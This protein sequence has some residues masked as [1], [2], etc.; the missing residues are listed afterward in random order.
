MIGKFICILFGIMSAVSF[1]QDPSYEQIEELIQK[2]QTILRFEPDPFTLARTQEAVDKVYFRFLSIIKKNGST[3]PS[4][5]SKVTETLKKEKTYQ[6][7]F[8]QEILDETSEHVRKNDLKKIEFQASLQALFLLKAYIQKFLVTQETQEDQEN[9]NKES[10]EDKKN[11][12]KQKE[13][14]QKEKKP[15]REDDEEYKDLDADQYDPHTKDLENDNNDG[16][17]LKKRVLAETNVLTEYFKSGYMSQIVRNAKENNKA[18]QK[19]ELFEEKPVITT[20]TSQNYI[21]V[22]PFKNKSPFLLYLPS[23]MKPLKPVTE[24]ISIIRRKTGQ[25]EVKIHQGATLTDITIPLEE[26]LQILPPHLLDHYKQKVGFHLD[27]WPLEIR[28]VINTMNQDSSLSALQIAKAVAKLISSQYLYSTKGRP[29]KDPI[30]ALKAGAFQCDMAAYILIG[31]LRDYFQIPSRVAFG[32]RAKFSTK[33]GL[34]KRFL[35]S[36]ED[37]HAW[38]EIYEAGIWHPV[39]PTPTKKESKDQDDD[40]DDQSEYQDVPPEDPD[41][42]SEDQEKSSKDQE[43]ESQ[44]NTDKSSKDSSK[45]EQTPLPLE[46]ESKESDQSKEDSLEDMI[47]REELIQQ[48]EMDSATLIKDNSSGP[49]LTYFKLKLLK[50]TIDPLNNNEAIVNKLYILKNALKRSSDTLFKNK[51]EKFIKDHSLPH[52]SLQNWLSSLAILKDPK[53]KHQSYLRVKHYLTDYASILNTLL[54]TSQ[55]KTLEKLRAE[56]I[57]ILLVIEDILKKIASYSMSTPERISA[58]KQFYQ[59]L[60]PM[61]KKYIKETYNIKELGINKETENLGTAIFNGQLNHLI[62]VSNLASQADFNLSG[63]PIPEFALFKAWSEDARYPTGRDILP[64]TKMSDLPRAYLG[65]PHKSWEENIN[66]STVF[67]I[68]QKEVFEVPDESGDIDETER[69]T[70]IGFDQSG[71]MFGIPAE[72]QAALM[73]AFVT[74]AFSDVSPTGKQ[75]HKIL[76][77]PFHHDVLPE[78]GIT[79]SDDAINVLHNYKK[80]QEATGGTDIQKFLIQALSLIANAQ[81]RTGEPLAKANIILMTDG[82]AN[83]DLQELKEARRVIDRSTPIQTIFVSLGGGNDQL[84]EFS[85]TSKGI[86]IKESFYRE[87]SRSDMETLINESKDPKKLWSNEEMFF[88]SELKEIPSEGLKV[89][90]NH[91]NSLMWEYDN[92]LEQDVQ[93]R[94]LKDILRDL[95]SINAL[96]VASNDVLIDDIASVRRLTGKLKEKNRYKKLDAILSR[97]YKDYKNIMSKP[98]SQMSTHELESFVHLFKCAEGLE[99]CQ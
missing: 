50:D 69:I 76:L 93:Y 90:Y 8:V 97:V 91:L 30:D 39:D 37:G 22:Y 51:I 85:S 23:K 34:A 95:G 98:V 46:D 11:P 7:Q 74:K 15:Q 94:S 12:K 18:F 27:E 49:L 77:V 3:Y 82:E 64:L 21:K 84:R 38:V 28:N 24:P 75:R 63:D 6:D 87:F 53:S 14:K 78:I 16:D 96:Q 2:H 89:H 60:N 58:A 41:E 79:T 20:S 66:E 32:Y 62:L 52:P 86:G 48:L 1:A 65:Q 68:K 70:I 5:F 80:L 73:M 26:D 9:E 44:K 57:E 25:Y 56:T 33:N 99:T 17:G 81:Q 19:V 31:I 72:F 54:K 92:T 88:P 59:S 4:T 10:H 42:S 36:K 13:K 35:L 83:I 40:Q 45:P 29:E 67:V 47:K 71:S 61:L 43:N 55:D